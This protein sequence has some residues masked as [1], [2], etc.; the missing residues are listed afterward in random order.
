MG[1]FF[2]I[3]AGDQS[4]D[5]AKK[6]QQEILRSQKLSSEFLSYTKE[7]PSLVDDQGNPRLVLYFDKDELK[8]WLVRIVKGLFFYRNNKT[9]IS[10][11][12][13]YEVEPLSEYTP[14][15]SNTF[16]PED[17]LEFI[18]HFSYCAVA[19]D[20]TDFWVLIFYDYLMFSVT[21]KTSTN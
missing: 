14:Q 10:D 11:S 9:R 13:V 1:N 15:P 16:P 7:H 21:V 3:I 19:K 6:A 20:K 17:G 5:L 18:P 2:A 12:A 8:H 4:G